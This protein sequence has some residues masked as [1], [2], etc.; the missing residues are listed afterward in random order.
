MIFKAPLNQDHSMTPWL[1]VV[2]EGVRELALLGAKLLQISS[3]K[4]SNT[5]TVF[6]FFK[7]FFF[8]AAL[9]DFLQCIQVFF[10]YFLQ[11]T[12]VPAHL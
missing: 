7:Y 9:A 12:L 3:I 1:C 8:N 4:G 11:S 6:F 10:I 5:I 2:V